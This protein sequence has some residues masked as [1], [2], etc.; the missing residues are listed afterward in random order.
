MCY[1]GY[2]YVEAKSFKV[3]SEIGNNAIRLAEQNKGVHQAVH[4]GKSLMQW[5]TKTVE[6]MIR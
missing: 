6:K 1:L 2:F 5:L 3:W 4:F